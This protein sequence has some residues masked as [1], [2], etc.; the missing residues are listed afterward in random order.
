MLAGVVANHIPAY[1]VGGE[2]DI[3]QNG[4]PLNYAELQNAWAGRSATAP[5]RPDSARPAAT[6]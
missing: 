5:M 3:F 1:M 4:E 2:F 6:S